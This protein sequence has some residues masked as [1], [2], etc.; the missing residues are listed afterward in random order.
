MCQ[1]QQRRVDRG[2][3]WSY[4]GRVWNDLKSNAGEEGR[5]KSYEQFEESSLMW[6]GRVVVGC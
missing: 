6:S 3:L 1:S 2:I 5:G 4:C